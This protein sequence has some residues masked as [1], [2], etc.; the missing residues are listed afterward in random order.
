M[1]KRN[2]PKGLLRIVLVIN[3]CIIG[4]I[5]FYKGYLSV[6]EK[7]FVD[8][9]YDNIEQIKSGDYED[10][11]SFVVLGNIKNSIHI[12]D[13]NIVNKINDD[14]DI[15]FVISTGNAVRDGAEDKYKILYRSLDKLDVP[16]IVGVGDNEITTE[17]G[18]PHYYQQY[19]DLYFSF[20]IEE[21]YFIFLDT[22]GETPFGRQKTWLEEELQTAKAYEDIFVFMNRPPFKVSDHTIF[23]REDKYIKSDDE[24]EFFTQIFSQYDVSAVF[25]SGSVKYLEQTIDGIPYYISG[26]AGGELILSDSDSFYHYTK[27]TLQDDE[28]SI[29]YVEQDIPSNNFLFRVLQ[30]MW[31]YI[32]SLFYTSAINIILITCIVISL[33][34]IIYNLVTKEVNYYREF[35]HLDEFKINRDKKLNIAMFTN[36][37]F[38]FIGGV[39]ISIRRLAE[40][41]MKN[42]HNVFIFA[43]E[44]PVKDDK[45]EE[46]VIRCKLLL[47]YKGSAFNFAIA[48]IFK[49][50]I[51]KDFLSYH[52]DLIHVHHPFW[53]GKK[54]LKLG[55]THNIPVVLTYHTRLEKYAHYLPLFQTTFQNLFS[56]FMIKRFSQRC[57]AIIAPTTTAKEYLENIGVSREKFVLPTGICLD[58]YQKVSTDEINAIKSM[59]LNQTINRIMSVYC[60]QYL[61]YQKRK[62]S[63]FF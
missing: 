56:H 52:F 47:Y 46:H 4:S 55:K 33:G 32:H 37:Y 11:L 63:I 30:N 16:T 26:G 39:P 49:T 19:G 41:L 25:S 38:P 44:Y 7:D 50:A 61:D 40:G 1:E 45:N 54:G 2:K 57:D 18:L 62:T 59:L 29:G 43:P 51:E 31:V 10:D 14:K 58:Q 17:K 20:N 42:G 60:V 13:R 15:D 53:M 34:I 21:S 12:F 5:F 24:R 9:N 23:H 27:V 48:N 36:N 3:L 28:L 8:L 22:T 6:K 35:D